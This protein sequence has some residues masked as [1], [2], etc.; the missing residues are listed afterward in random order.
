MDTAEEAFHCAKRFLSYPPLHAMSTMNEVV[1]AIPVP[2]HG[3]YK[4]YRLMRASGRRRSLARTITP[5]PAEVDL[6]VLA[7]R[8][9]Y[10]GSPEHKNV[11]SFAVS[12][13]RVQ[14]QPSVT[15]PLL[16]SFRSFIPGCS[17][18][19][20]EELL[21]HHGKRIFRAMPGSK[22]VTSCMRPG[23]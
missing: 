4:G 3:H 10:V 13:D 6:G 8:V 20:N 21:V 7:T 5:P 16:G 14:T 9:R 1:M 18:L 19:S 17:Q 11:P 15:A 23:L 2:F 22:M 12:L